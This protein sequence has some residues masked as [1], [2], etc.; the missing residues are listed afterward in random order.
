MRY[1]MLALVVNFRS[2]LDFFKNRE[3][4]MSKFYPS[5]FAHWTLNPTDFNLID[6]D[7][8]QV[9]RFEPRRFIVRAEGHD[10]LDSFDECVQIAFTLAKDDF[11]IADFFAINFESMQVARTFTK[12]KQTRK[13]FAKKFISDLAIEILPHDGKTDYAVS[14]N[15]SDN[16]D[17]SFQMVDGRRTRANI[18]LDKNITLGPVGG[19]EIIEKWLEFKEES[20]HE[21]YR[22]TPNVPDTANM[23]MVKFVAKPEPP[24]QKI[25]YD[26][27]VHFYD[28]AEQQTEDIWKRTL[29]G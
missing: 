18:I 8:R 9:I 5:K 11:N 17:G 12:I 19:D 25:T 1:A 6:T 28:W 15:R 23:L 3:T 14:V 21:P 13:E 10:S 29:G 2:T 26:I 4:A 22:T 16:V 24:Q 7:S 20:Q 27:M